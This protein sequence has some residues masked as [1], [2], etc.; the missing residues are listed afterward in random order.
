MSNV[1]RLRVENCVADMSL[2]ECERAETQSRQDRNY[3]YSL[4]VPYSSIFQLLQYG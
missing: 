1:A 3:A 2:D 4:E